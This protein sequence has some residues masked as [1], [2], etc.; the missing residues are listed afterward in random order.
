MA[1]FGRLM[2]NEYIKMLRRVST[3]IMIGLILLAV[4]GYIGLSMLAKVANSTMYEDEGQY[5]SDM[6]EQNRTNQQQVLQNSHSTEAEKQNAQNQLAFYDFLQ[7][8]DITDGASWRWKA[9][10]YAMIELRDR[11]REAGT[12]T[13]YDTDIATVQ[14]AVRTENAKAY[15]EV[16]LRVERAF[17]TANGTPAAEIEQM[18]AVE[19]YCYDHDIV[20][21]EEDKAFMLVETAF[22]EKANLANMEKSIEA[23]ETV[24]NDALRQQQDKT[25]LATYRLEHN[26][27]YD[28]SENTS[29]MQTGEF[30]FWSIFGG[31]SALLSFVG[32]LMIILAGGIV[33]NEF[34][35]GTIKF[36][37]INPVKRWKILASKYATA[38]SFG[39]VLLFLCYLLSALLCVIFFG[40]DNLGAEYYYVVDGAVKSLSGFVYV[41]RS[42]LLS[43]VNIV[44][45]AS[46]AFAL[47]SL[48]R[49]AA[50]AIGV[51]LM[52]MFG[53]N[54]AVSILAAMQLDWGRFLIF[55]NTDL[56]LIANGNTMFIG[57]TMP[58]AL[59][60]IA[61]HMLV[62]LLT[63]WDGFVRREV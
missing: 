37:L 47:S 18:F 29:W 12:P 50:L 1:K 3:K 44:I 40:A 24:T 20:P 16:K 45:M 30:D 19:Q 14:D 2:Q 33:A 62:F 25:L 31:S 23:G 10:S 56:D 54:L 38:V 46:L 49:S 6:L 59:V 48:V 28:I 17:E 61:V 22:S 34:S 13:V 55:A 35:Q 7:E 8:A 41:L 36:L 15:L 43:S 26:I 32:V 57:Q 39:Y 63:A 11:A 52:A 9:L 21:Q 51:G 5:W 42:Y 53:G 60:I 58:F 4:L 27:T